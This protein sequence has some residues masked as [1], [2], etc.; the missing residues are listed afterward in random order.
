[1]NGVDLKISFNQQLNDPQHVVIISKKGNVDLF[2]QSTCLPI[3]ERLTV[4][5]LDLQ[6]LSKD[7]LQQYRDEGRIVVLSRDG[8]GD[9]RLGHRLNR[10]VEFSSTLQ[11]VEKK[12]SLR[13]EISG[14]VKAEELSK[15]EYDDAY[16]G[17]LKT[18]SASEEKNSCSDSQALAMISKK[19][20][21]C[22]NQISGKKIAKKLS[23]LVRNIDKFFENS[24]GASI[25]EIKKAGEKRRYEQK[26][27][28]ILYF[29]RQKAVVS[30]AIEG[31]STSSSS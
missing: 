20:H 26:R 16:D 2:I 28:L 4:K 24:E 15:E 1:M 5:R 13:Y 25:A 11:L 9:I 22:F 21:L 23:N 3:I 18:M 8:N 27:E 30:E 14:N 17:Y 10:H 6:T 31:Y 19:V 7:K 12:G 29:I